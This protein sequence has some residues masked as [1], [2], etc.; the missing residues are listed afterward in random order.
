VGGPEPRTVQVAFTLPS[1]WVQ[2]PEPGA[3]PKGLLRRDPFEALAREIVASGAVIAPLVNPT[4][5]YLRRM[6]EADPGA[7]GVVCHIAAP[8]RTENTFA[9]VIVVGPVRVPE[10]PGGGIDWDEVTDLA[11]RPGPEDSTH[12]AEQVQLPWGSGVKA[13]WTRKRGAEN[14]ANAKHVVAYWVVADDLGALITVQ[15]DVSTDRPPELEQILSDI[16]AIAV[17]LKV[18]PG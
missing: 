10:R 9:N 13:R 16:D 14:L 2:L 4:R 7:L 3:K 8:S 17:S 5:D 12:A 18:S 6:A 11:A 15:G 1:G